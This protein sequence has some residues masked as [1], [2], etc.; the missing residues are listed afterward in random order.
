MLSDRGTEIPS[1]QPCAIRVRALCA[2]GNCLENE[3]LRCSSCLASRTLVV[4]LGSV[5]EHCAG[6]ECSENKILR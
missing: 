2:G 4:C 5:F 3:I 6:T 1:G